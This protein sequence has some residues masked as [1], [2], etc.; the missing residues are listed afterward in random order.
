MTLSNYLHK[1]E[2]LPC[3][4]SLYP[5]LSAYLTILGNIANEICFGK[6]IMASSNCIL[7][8]FFTIWLYDIGIYH[9]RNSWQIIVNPY[10]VFIWKILHAVLQNFLQSFQQ[11]LKNTQLELHSTACTLACRRI[12]LQHI[13]SSCSGLCIISAFLSRYVK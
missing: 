13:A 6:N 8:I 5:A 3:N 11:R 2:T 1:W 10:H 9:N 4:T 7:D 12:W